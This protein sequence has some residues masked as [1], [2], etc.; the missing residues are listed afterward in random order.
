VLIKKERNDIQGIGRTIDNM[1][2]LCDH[3]QDI[4]IQLRSFGYQGTSEKKDV[5]LNDLINQCISSGQENSH[6]K[7][8]ITSDSGDIIVNCNAVIVAMAINNLI[9]NAVEAACAAE[10]PQV[11]IS[12]QSTPISVMIAIEDNGGLMTDD[13]ATNLFEPFFST[14]GADKGLGLG[15]A[16]VNNAIT[17]SGGSISLEFDSSSTRFTIELPRRNFTIKRETHAE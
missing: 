8:L 2:P 5:E 4:I 16:I 12:I 7:I 15:L 11:T 9:K 13:I 3:M 1:A 14:K 17:D 10:T 6:I